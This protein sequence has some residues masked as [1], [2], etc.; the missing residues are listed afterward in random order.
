VVG[1]GPGG[2]PSPRRD[3]TLVYIPGSVEGAGG[4]RVILHGGRASTGHTAL[5][6]VWSFDIL[7]EVWSRLQDC[8]AGLYGHSSVLYGSRGWV[9]GGYDGAANSTTANLMS[10]DLVSGRWARE[11]YDGPAPVGRMWHTATMHGARMHVVG[12]MNSGYNEYLTWFELNFAKATPG[13]AAGTWKRNLGRDTQ[14]GSGR[15][16]HAAAVVK[17]T[18]WIFGGSGTS[19][20]YNDFKAYALRDDQALPAEY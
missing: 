1:V 14:V 7:A 4:P 2:V 3:A 13:G 18:L 8:P 19:T 20:Y 11:V 12:G 6:D 5:D 17:D 15:F 10:Y 9:F 16:L